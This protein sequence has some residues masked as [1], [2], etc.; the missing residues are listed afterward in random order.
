MRLDVGL[1]ANKQVSFL[2]LHILKAYEQVQDKIN[3]LSDR[4]PYLEIEDV[5]IIT[6]I[7]ENGSGL[8]AGVADRLDAAQASSTPDSALQDNTVLMS[9]V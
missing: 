7:K 9:G 4:T 2:K 1:S 8:Y 5:S 3:E 6:K